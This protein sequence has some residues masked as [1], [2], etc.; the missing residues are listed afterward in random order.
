[1]M[2]PGGEPRDGTSGRPS[3]RPH[4]NPEPRPSRPLPGHLPGGRWPCRL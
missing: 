3:R 2:I 1:M 4:A